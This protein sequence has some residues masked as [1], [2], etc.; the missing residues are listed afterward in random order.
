MPSF[1]LEEKDSP[2]VST[3]DAS[4]LRLYISANDIYDVNQRVREVGFVCTSTKHRT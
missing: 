3:W 4:R 1:R 2:N